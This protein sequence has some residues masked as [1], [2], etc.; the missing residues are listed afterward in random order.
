MQKVIVNKRVLK[1]K[2]WYS[3]GE[4]ICET[5]LTCEHCETLL[6]CEHCEHCE[7]EHCE[8]EY[9]EHCEHCEHFILI[10]PN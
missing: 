3:T 7:Q 10:W 4:Q 5:L 2:E 6:T 9:C 8:Q 1:T